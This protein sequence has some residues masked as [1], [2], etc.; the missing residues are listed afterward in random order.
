MY[1]VSIIYQLSDGRKVLRHR[2]GYDY[3]PDIE[4]IKTRRRSRGVIVYKIFI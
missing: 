4:H 1:N 2:N 3:K